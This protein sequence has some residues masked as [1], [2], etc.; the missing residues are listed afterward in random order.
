MDLEALARRA[1]VTP[2]QVREWID[3]GL[4]HESSSGLDADSLERAQLL[5]AATARGIDAATIAAASEREG[6]ILG[7]FVALGG[8]GRRG[9][10]RLVGERARD[11]GLDVT[12]VQRLW[13]AAGLG[14]QEADEDDAAMMQAV[15][16]ALDAGL[17]EEALL[18]LVR[19]YADALGRVADAET[20][21]FHFYVYERLQAEGADPAGVAEATAQAS[22]SLV[23]LTEP[24]VLYFH[25]KAW[26]RALRQ[27]FLDHHLVE[28]VG[29]AGSVG[30]LAVAVLFVD[31]AQFT[32][33]TE[34]M[35]DEA[36]AVVVDRF[37]Q[38]VRQEALRFDGRVVKQIGDEF[39]LVFP[40]ADAS[41]RCALHLADR[42]SEEAHFP[43]L[44]MGG[45]VGNAL[46]RE[47]DYVGAT[48]N[49][50]ARVVSQAAPMQLAVTRTVVD[51]IGDPDIA[52][53]RLGHQSLKG[54]SEPVELFALTLA[55]GATAR[56]TDPVCGMMLPPGGTPTLLRWHGR[57]IGFCSERC[58]E[59]FERDPSAFTGA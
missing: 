16:Q 12:F 9:E 35:G 17:P 23:G 57:D 28:Y 33:L 21:L 8:G 39:M 52:W 45:H 49:L 29:K 41:V 32:P 25:R 58:R 6:D 37:S 54:V 24:S 56:Q 51:S 47:A 42:A 50:A 1:G 2:E 4:V 22:D 46:Y 10:S 31:L 13:I 38:L 7:R 40:S 55:D 34:A 43:A 3:L 20:R 14:E 48:V 53:Q 26:R 59:R 27:D 19:V 44:R 30:E 18:Q 5:L 15:R 11:A 36:A